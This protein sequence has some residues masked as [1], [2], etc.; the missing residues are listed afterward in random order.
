MCELLLVLAGKALTLSYSLIE[1]GAIHVQLHWTGV[2][3]R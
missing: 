1:Q 2:Q 3:D